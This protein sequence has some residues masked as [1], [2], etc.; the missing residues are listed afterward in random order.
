MHPRFAPTWLAP[1]L[2]IGPLAPPLPMAPAQATEPQAAVASTIAQAGPPLVSRQ[3]LSAPITGPRSP[4]P[5][6]WIGT[7]EVAPDTP[8]LVM[9]GHADS[10]NIAGSGTSGAAVA[11]GAPPMYPGISDEL[12]WNMVIAQAVVALGQQRGLRISY[13]RPPFRTILDG[14][15]T[16]TNWSMGRN[17]VASGGYALEIHF[18]AW[19]S[20]GIGSGLMPPLHRSFSRIDESLAQEFGA[21]P[22]AFRGGLGAPRRGIALLEIGKLEGGLEASL[23]SP[24]H[25][26][27]TVAE[28]ATRIVTALEIGLGRTGLTP[29][30]GAAGNGPPAK[31]LQASSGGG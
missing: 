24:V 16:G 2:L 3:A 30:P 14:D 11:A 27:R 29:P 22:M 10:Q 7:R 8:I 17:H 5:K 6:D 31:G 20:S 26:E 23:R 19:G 25:R 18:D 4:L 28:I 13:Y 21:Y 12:Y 9:A 1:A 15:D